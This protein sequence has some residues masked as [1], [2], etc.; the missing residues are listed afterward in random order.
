V[1]RKAAPVAALLAMA[2]GN[3]PT[4]PRPR[5]KQ[6]FNERAPAVVELRKMTG[7]GFKAALY[8]IAE[9]EP[10]DNPK[11]WAQRAFDRINH[12]TLPKNGTPTDRPTCHSSRGTRASLT[13]NNLLIE[14]LYS[15]PRAACL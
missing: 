14:F 4:P 6:T 2:L 11:V 12:R 1:K 3:D 10:D 9:T 13:S 7:L 5:P 8:A 15:T